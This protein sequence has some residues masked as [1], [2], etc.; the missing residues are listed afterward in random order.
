MHKSLNNCVGPDG[1]VPTLHVYG[2]LPRLGLP[3]NKLSTSVFE[4]AVSVRKASEAMSR[5]FSKCQL[6]DALKHWNGP[7]VFE[8]H[9]TP[10][11]AKL[12]TYRRKTN[13]SEGPIILLVIH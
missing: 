13:A 7:D 8:I 10:I 5:Y 11:G 9:N 12:L 3:T 2:A 1:L 4:Q 6:L